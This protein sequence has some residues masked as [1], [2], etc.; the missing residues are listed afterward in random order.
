MLVTE[1]LLK[2]ILGRMGEEYRIR[3]PLGRL[4]NEYIRSGL[5]K[6]RNR[7]FDNP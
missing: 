5:D 1:I 7:L 4:S 3:Y 2:L 6:V